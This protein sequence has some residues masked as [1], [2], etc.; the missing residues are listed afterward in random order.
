MTG[1]EI[2]IAQGQAL[3]R[4]WYGHRSEKVGSIIFPEKQEK[5]LYAKIDA[6][7]EMVRKDVRDIVKTGTRV[8]V[9]LGAGAV[10][11]LALAGAILWT[12]W[13][14]KPDNPGHNPGPPYPPM[15]PAEKS[16]AAVTVPEEIE[17]W[18]QGRWGSRQ[19]AIAVGLSRARN[20]G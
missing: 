1:I 2:K 4:E 11:T 19:Q 13:A 6:I 7:Q 17:A 12:R 9:G 8:S 5:R 10:A 15:S 14:G 16:R 18:K 3:D 20:E